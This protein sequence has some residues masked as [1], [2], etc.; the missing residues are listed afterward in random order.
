[1]DRER[2]RIGQ[3]GSGWDSPP[4]KRRVLRALEAKPAGVG[5]NPGGGDQ[6]EEW[7]ELPP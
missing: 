3:G 1:M 4:D 5:I 2:A 7:L 6:G